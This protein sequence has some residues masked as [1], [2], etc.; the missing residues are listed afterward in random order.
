M[1]LASPLERML[2]DWQV[3]S[4]FG[5][6]CRGLV[7]F[8]QAFFGFPKGK[9]MILIQKKS[10]QATQRLIIRCW[11]CALG[12]LCFLA[13]ASSGVVCLGNDV[14]PRSLACVEKHA[15]S[16]SVGLI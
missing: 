8:I 9:N 1:D 12:C 11:P 4:R 2:L 10:L 14:V 7:V 6:R 3:K 13:A 15:G 16:A 5:F